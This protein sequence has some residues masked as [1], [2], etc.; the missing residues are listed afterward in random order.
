MQKRRRGVA[1]ENNSVAIE[2]DNIRENNFRLT[3]EKSFLFHFFH[4]FVDIMAYN[5]FSKNMNLWFQLFDIFDKI[6]FIILILLIK[7]DNC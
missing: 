6:L 2:L 1:L 5:I 3:V 4:H 7:I